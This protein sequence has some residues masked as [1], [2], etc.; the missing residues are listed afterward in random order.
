MAFKMH[1]IPLALPE[2]EPHST[3][4]HRFD[5]HLQFRF[6]FIFEWRHVQLAASSQHIAMI[7]CNNEVTS[8][9]PESQLY[10]SIITATID[11]CNFDFDWMAFARNAPFAMQKVLLSEV[12]RYA[13]ESKND[14]L[15]WKTCT[16]IAWQWTHLTRHLLLFLFRDFVAV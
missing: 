10:N 15:K 13:L 7:L 6:L 16:R 2:S 3:R 14:G 1:W 5:L 8:A 9:C 4:L 12:I 11:L